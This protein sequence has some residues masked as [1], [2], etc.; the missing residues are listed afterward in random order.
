MIVSKGTQEEEEAST[1]ERRGHPH[2]NVQNDQYRL[3][4]A[5]NPLW[6]EQEK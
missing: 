4:R 5:E 6:N 1:L 3:Q 2:G